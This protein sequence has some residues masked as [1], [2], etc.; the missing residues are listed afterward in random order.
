MS[1]VLL[2]C[3]QGS[4]AAMLPPDS[5]VVYRQKVTLACDTYNLSAE[6][7]TSW[8]ND[9]SVIILAVSGKDA[10][11][12]D[13]F[14]LE[15]SR[16]E[17]YVIHLPND[18]TIYVNS[19]SSIAFNPQAPNFFYIESGEVLIDMKQ[20]S[21]IY[22]TPKLFIWALSGTRLNVKH[23]DANL[24]TY[25]DLCFLRG[26]AKAVMEKTE[27][28]LHAELTYTYTNAGLAG[29]DTDTT[30]AKAW[31]N[32]SFNYRSIGYNYLVKRIADW[33]R[34]EVVFKDKIPQSHISFNGFFSEPL[35]VVL[36]RLNDKR[37]KTQCRIESD[38]LIVE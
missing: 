1:L 38:K 25:T 9:D 8:K 23:Y 11:G 7:I 14:T 34:K 20:N 31:V 17:K 32:E 37:K 6:R 29:I 15:T 30:D 19:M 27:R 22:I 10:T 33:Y 36:S 18:N 4:H 5:N 13:K 21:K 12:F 24:S 3:T 35:A 2:S 28:I 26:E 16:G